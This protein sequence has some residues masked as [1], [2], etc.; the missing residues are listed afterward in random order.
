[1]RGCLLAAI[2]KKGLIFPFVGML[3]LKM[4]MSNDVYVFLDDPTSMYISYVLSLLGNYSQSTDLHF[5]FHDVAVE[6]RA[7]VSTG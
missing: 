1:M 4:W 3:C 5:I 6:I 7:D 2:K